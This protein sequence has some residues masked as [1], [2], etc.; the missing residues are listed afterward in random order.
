MGKKQAF[1]KGYKEDGDYK[2]SINNG[3]NRAKLNRQRLISKLI[4]EEAAAAA[5][6][7][8]A[9][10]NNQEQTDATNQNVGVQDETQGQ[11][12]ADDVANMTPGQVINYV[13]VNMPENIDAATKQALLNRA[14][15]IRKDAEARKDT[16][17]RAEQILNSIKMILPELK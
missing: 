17:Q 9:M 5:M 6:T 11:I 7:P 15:Q 8:S 10:N 16:K 2:S 3:V 14:D 1:D 4:K 12:T 13:Y